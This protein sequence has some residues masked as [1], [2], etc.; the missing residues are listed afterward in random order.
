MAEELGLSPSYLNLMER[1]QR[2]ITA[3]VLIRLVPRLFARPARIRHGRSRA[4]RDGTGGGLRRPAVPQRPVP[5]L[6]L[7]ETVEAAPSLVDAVNRLYRAYQAMRGAR[8]VR[9][10]DLDRPRPGG[11]RGR[12]STRSTGCASPSRR[13]R[14]IFR[15]WTRPPRRLASEL[16]D[17]GHELFFALSERLHA[18]HGI[19]VRVMPI[20][21]MP[22]TLRRYDHHRRQ[23]LISEIVD[24]SG[25]H[26][27]GRLSARLRR[28][29][30]RPS[31][32]WR[33]ASSPWTARRGVCCGSP[34]ATI[35]PAR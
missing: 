29:A 4:H 6:E 28:D 30:R 25:P 34:S 9:D 8:E 32:R 15:N 10:A 13:P 12:R 24:P 33:P 1:N 19:R 35:S 31:I 26:L 16:A 22:D 21:V 27:P 14:T 17:T 23:L 2:P 11:G 7:R 3:Q 5:R 18:K 20:D